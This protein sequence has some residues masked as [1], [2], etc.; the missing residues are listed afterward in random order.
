M[1]V[2]KKD[3]GAVESCGNA[4]LY[5]L[6]NTAGYTA[7]FTDYG[8]TWVAW[9]IPDAAGAFSDVV[10]GFDSAEKYAEQK[11]YAGAVCGRVANRI[12]G[13]KFLPDGKEY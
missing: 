13:G 4:T 11:A 9:L 7:S 6:K 5:T 8:A 3:F 12:A 10:L 1:P 2:E